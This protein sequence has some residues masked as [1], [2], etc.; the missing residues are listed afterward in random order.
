MVFIIE[1]SDGR[2][3]WF[4]N[5]EFLYAIDYAVEHSYGCLFRFSYYRDYEDLFYSLYA[6]Q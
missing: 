4:D 5:V 6:R 1:Y 2:D 3:V